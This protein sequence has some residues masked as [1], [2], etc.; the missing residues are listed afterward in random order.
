MENADSKSCEHDHPNNS[1]QENPT[2]GK[3]KKIDFS[4]M[5]LD[6]TVSDNAVSEKRRTYDIEKQF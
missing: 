1:F 5:S 6:N 2:V 4:N 3:F